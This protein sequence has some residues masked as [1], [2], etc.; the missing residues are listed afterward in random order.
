MH[1]E[2]MLD[3]VCN[4]PVSGESRETKDWPAATFWKPIEERSIWLS[5]EVGRVYTLTQL[6]A[7]QQTLRKAPKPLVT[8]V[9]P[10]KAC[11]LNRTE[12]SCY[13]SH[14]SAVTDRGE[15]DESLIPGFPPILGVGTVDIC[16]EQPTG[17]GRNA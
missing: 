15:F 13:F 12:M 9:V 5:R 11:W 10:L 2:V 17:M 6:L 4:V 16:C 14:L 7:D 1:A 3:P 8:P